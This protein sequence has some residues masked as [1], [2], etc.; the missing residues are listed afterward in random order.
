MRRKE[1]EIDDQSI[2]DKILSTSDIC[3]IAVMDGNRPY[4]VPLNYGN[5]GRTLYFHSSKFGKKIDLLKQNNQVCFEIESPSELIKNE[6]ACDWGTKYRSI[7]GYGAIDFITDPE[8]KKFDLDAI[9]SHYGNTGEKVYNERLI[10]LI[11]ILKLNIREISG[12][13]SGSWD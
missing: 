4:I 3:R 10:E 11:V 9:M 1:K 7:I 13:Q 8:E 12:K 6:N 5:K 2:I